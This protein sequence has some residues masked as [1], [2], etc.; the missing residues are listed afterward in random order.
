VLRIAQEDILKYK[1]QIG[2]LQRDNRLLQHE[3]DRAN[4]NLLD[5]EARSDAANNVS[6]QQGSKSKIASSKHSATPD[7]GGLPRRSSSGGSGDHNSVSKSGG[8]GSVPMEQVKMMETTLVMV[9]NELRRA[10]GEKEAFKEERDSLK[11]QTDLLKNEIDALVREKDK[12]SLANTV[13]S[14]QESKHVVLG[15]SRRGNLDS[16]SDSES[17]T[18]EG[19]KEREKIASPPSVS[20]APESSLSVAVSGVDVEEYRTLCAKFKNLCDV[21]GTIFLSKSYTNTPMYTSHEH[22][23][24]PPKR[25]SILTIVPF[26]TVGSHTEKEQ[27]RRESLE[28]HLLSL[29]RTGQGEQ[30]ECEA[31]VQRERERDCEREESQLSVMDAK[32]AMLTSRSECGRLRADLSHSFD[33]LRAAGNPISVY[34]YVLLST[35]CSCSVT[36]LLHPCPRSGSLI[37][38]SSRLHQPLP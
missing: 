27:L 16:V 26:L 8:R 21:L 34:A 25:K 15:S 28:E 14:S 3:A 9:R 29:R 1:R 19:R 22:I 32:A 10:L 36:H 12:I 2:E 20:S 24:P 4:K 35:P 31:C 18:Q 17:L 33:C 5:Y 30:R 23:L 6:T 13:L 7:T 38:L 11:E 37:S